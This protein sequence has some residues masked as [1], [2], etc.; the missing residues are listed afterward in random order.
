MG[1]PG[2]V[3]GVNSI[4]MCRLLHQLIESLPELFYL[5]LQASSLPFK[6]RHSAVLQVFNHLMQLW[7]LR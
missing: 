6:F 4:D 7:L 5:L 3:D 1:S 2:V